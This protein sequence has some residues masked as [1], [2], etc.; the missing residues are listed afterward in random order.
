MS[1]HFSSTIFVRL[2]GFLGV[3]QLKRGEKGKIAAVFLRL[4]QQ[5][6]HSKR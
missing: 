1:S 4:L 2:A 5:L 6:L 3:A